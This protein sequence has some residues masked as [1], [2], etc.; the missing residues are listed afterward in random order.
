MSQNIKIALLLGGTSPEK[1]VAKNTAK[2]ILKALRELGYQVTPINPAYG[3]N[4]PRDENLFFVM[5]E[6]T[7]PTNRNYIEA[8]NSSLLDNIDLA[9]LALHGRWGEDGTIQSLLEM[10][11]IR[12]TG[13]GILASS[14]AMDKS[15]TKVVIQHAGVST[16]E[17]LVV[18]KHETNFAKVHTE[19]ISKFDYPCVIKPNDQGSTVGLT[20]CK[21]ES[22]V[23][24]A[25]KLSLKFSSKALIEKYIPGRELTVSVLEGRAL[26]VLE[27]KPKSGFYDYESKYTAGMS[28]YICP[29]ELKDDLVK[30]LQHQALLAFNA[31][32]CD[33]Y[34]RI[35]FRLTDEGKFFCLEINTLP[36]M[37]NLSLVPKA[38]KAAGIS[39]EDLVD[40][41]VK[42]ALR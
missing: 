23:E 42:N 9:Y 32:G 4:Q 18:D 28:E 34:S 19:I 8:I 2:S 35:D 25:I 1:E 27:I 11:G 22:Q 14:L 40:R 13:S 21:D 5:E 20:I 33:T 12:Y 30:R 3:I 39:F 16:P 36:G 38:A 7:E 24:D 31:V 37:T 17:W 6:F 15:M 29:A 26:P 41:I 10:R